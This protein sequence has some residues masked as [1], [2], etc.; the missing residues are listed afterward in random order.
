MASNPEAVVRRLVD[1][2]Y[3]RGEFERFDELFTA[4]TID[5]TPLPGQPPTL[6]APGIDGVL[7][8]MRLWRSAFADL[9]MTVHELTTDGELV[10]WRWTAAATHVGELA[11]ITP[12]GEAVQMHGIELVRMSGG[13]IAERWGYGNFAELMLHLQVSHRGP[14]DPAEPAEGL[15]VLP[16]EQ[17]SGGGDL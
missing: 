10:W 8:T 2:V 3:N 11:G 14:L 15:G 12:T 1:Q 16:T 17:A 13:K 4:D 7:A 5:H 9:E 6:Q